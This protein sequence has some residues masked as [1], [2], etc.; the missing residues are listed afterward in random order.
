MAECSEQILDKCCVLV[1]GTD[2]KDRRNMNTTMF[3]C[4]SEERRRKGGYGQVL[5]LLGLELR[6]ER[7]GMQ[8]TIKAPSIDRQL[9]I[10]R[11]AQLSCFK[12]SRVLLAMLEV[13]RHW[14]HDF[15]ASA[16]TRTHD[17]PAV[18]T[19]ADGQ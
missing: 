5:S 2:Q 16:R 18:L 17:L 1:L 7:G 4:G 13:T 19:G 3:D 14:R 9:A 11:A 15:D 12:A 6:S 10:R 8:R